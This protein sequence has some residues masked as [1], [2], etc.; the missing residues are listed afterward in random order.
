[1]TDLPK[2]TVLSV[3]GKKVL[4][5]ADMDV[6][7]GSKGEEFRLK[8]LIPTLKYL[9]DNKARTIIIGHKGRPEGKITQELSLELVVKELA[10]I[11]G[12]QISFFN[13]SLEGAK[14]ES[15][16]V[17]EE[18]FL[19]LENLRFDIRE[20]KND[21]AFAKELSELADFY[22]NEAFATHSAHASIVG[23]PKL[24]PHA[25][26]IRFL[27]EVEK[28]SGVLKNPKKPFVVVIGGAKKDKTDYIES[29]EGK[30][31]K[32]LVGGRLPEYMGDNTVSVRSLDADEKVVV[33]NLVMDKEDITIHSIERFEEEIAKAGTIVLAGP[34][35]KYEEEGHRQGTE[36]V[37]R[38]IIETGAYKIAGG[39]DT[40]AAI[41]LLGLENKFDWISVGGGAMLEFLAK[42]TLPSIEAL[43]G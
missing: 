16:K 27:E 38:A 26:G 32:I 28:L 31:D 36:R 5:R 8:A 2:I 9:S 21:S 7:I 18:G 15:E 40:I 37:L 25:A 33:A 6:E 35:G 22:V 29:L 39:G 24:L 41:Y 14:A 19:C 3:S 43:L 42:G 30:A 34:M 20:E 17:S 11:S 23:L 13:G 1:M 10:K 12:Y 4:L